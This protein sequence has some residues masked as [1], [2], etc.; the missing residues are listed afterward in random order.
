VSNGCGPVLVVWWSCL[1]CCSSLSLSFLLPSPGGEKRCYGFERE[2]LQGDERGKRERKQKEQETDNETRCTKKNRRV[3]Y[4]VRKFS[5][6][7]LFFLSFSPSSP[8]GGRNLS[9]LPTG[10]KVN[11]EGES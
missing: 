6:P 10:W 9:F 2:R 1:S 11:A 8:G 7:C 4:R 3:M 5:V